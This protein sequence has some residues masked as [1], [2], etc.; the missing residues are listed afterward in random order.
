MKTPC[1]RPPRRLSAAPTLL[2]AAIALVCA[3]A[4]ADDEPNPY[5]IGASQAFTHDSNIYRFADQYTTVDPVTQVQTLSPQPVGDTISSTGL[6]AGIDQPFGRQ[7]FYGSG[8]ARYNRYNDNHDLN[9]T[10]YSLDTGLDWSTIDR[11]SGKLHYTTRENLASYSANVL[12]LNSREKNIEHDQTFEATA[13]LGTASLFSV[14]GGYTYNSVHY[15]ADPFSVFNYHENAVRLGLK[16]R[17]SGALTLGIGARTTRGD[18]PDRVDASK[19]PAPLKMRR[20]DL[21]LT[22]QWEVSGL[23][24]LVARLSYSKQSYDNHAV[25]DFHGAT[26]S[27]GWDYRPTGR[28]HFSTYLARDT[29]QTTLDSTF[30]GAQYSADS[31]RLKTLAQVHAMYDLTGKIRLDGTARHEH[32]TLSDTNTLFNVSSSGSDSTNFYALGLT[33]SPLRSLT[34]ACSVS[35]ETR[36]SS[37]ISPL[38]YPFH[39]NLT[40]CSAQFVLR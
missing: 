14:D 22:G 24:T 19:Q 17:P 34:L 20:N 40:S 39:D 9:N 6:V 2:A 28:L 21:D 38:S 12:S 26:G 5:Y 10:S 23:S 36:T 15:S 35:R 29:G 30:L 25:G 18:Y 3:Q 4:K 7:H 13:Q 1:H 32:R 31:S 8:S 37:E 27:L 11:L 33:Y 16:Y